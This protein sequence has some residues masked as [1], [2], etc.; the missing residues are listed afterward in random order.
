ML[1]TEYRIRF[2]G[3]SPVFRP[4]PPIRPGSIQV[5]ETIVRAAASVGDGACFIFL[6]SLEIRVF[7]RCASAAAWRLLFARCIVC[8][9][10]SPLAGGRAERPGVRAQTRRDGNDYEDALR[11]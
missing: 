2:R 3:S 5:S 1:L 6:L 11:A 9:A 4:P 10:V 8:C 7:Q